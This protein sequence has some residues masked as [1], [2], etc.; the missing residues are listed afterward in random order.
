MAYRVKSD[1]PCHQCGEP[2]NRR[3]NK[4]RLPCCLECAVELFEQNTHNLISH[5]GPQ[6]DKWV[7]GMT[8]FMARE[9]MT[10]PPSTNG[11]NPAA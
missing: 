4:S 1:A 3:L 5:R 6:Y 8:K 10:S 2:T 9:G 7:A 11:D